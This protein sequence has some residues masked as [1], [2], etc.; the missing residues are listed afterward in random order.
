MIVFDHLAVSAATLEAGV[1]HV[2]DALG[3]A[4]ASGGKHAHMST[5][6][7]LLGLGDLYLE[8]IAADPDAPAPGWPRWFDL[9]NFAGP[10]RI[11]NWVARCDDLVAEVAASPAGIGIPT[12][13]ERGDLRWQMAVPEDGK[14]P[15]GGA[16]P[17]LIRWQGAHPVD[18]LPDTGLRLT[19]L[20]IAHPEAK[21]LAQALEGRFMDPR[22]VILQGDRPSMQASFSTPAGERRL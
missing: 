8:V 2:E 1:A 20:E 10:P 9:D 12:A 4:L 16:F 6:N 15:F 13:L 18:R 22:V 19:R 5:H 3:V 17:A 21:A 7:R 11:T 14:L